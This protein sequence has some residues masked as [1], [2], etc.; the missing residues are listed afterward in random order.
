MTR[1]RGGAGAEAGQGGAQVYLGT[2]TGKMQRKPERLAGAGGQ[3]VDVE[4]DRKT[5]SVRELLSLTYAAAAAS[6]TRGIARNEGRNWSRPRTTTS[7]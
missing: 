5:M 3:Y 2:P 6:A 1:S 4:L 7:A